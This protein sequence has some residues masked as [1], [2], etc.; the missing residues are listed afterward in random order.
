VNEILKR[1]SP[2]AMVLFIIAI[3]VIALLLANPFQASDI[4]AFNNPQ[5]VFNPLYYLVLIL[6]F[7]GFLLLS[8][9]S[10]NGG[11]YKLSLAS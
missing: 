3:Q 10:A 5:S 11:C 6:V 2:F 7:T 9:G 4:K 1:I 8:S